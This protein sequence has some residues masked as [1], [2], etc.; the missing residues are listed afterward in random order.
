MNTLKIRFYLFIFGCI[1]SRLFM[2]L[3]S[4]FAYGKILRAI[5]FLALLPVLGWLYIIFIGKR[6]TGLE[7][8]GGE[9]WWKNL[10]PIHVGLWSL[11]AYLSINGNRNSWIV[12]LVDTLF[13]LFAFL[14]HHYF[15]GNL[16]KMIY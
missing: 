6:D 13:G 4:S 1:L 10:R 5:G 7:V 9:I 15:A 8:F 16:G 2:T 11:F 14:W 12:L 3:L